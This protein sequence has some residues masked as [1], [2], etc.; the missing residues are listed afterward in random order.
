MEQYNSSVTFCE[1]EKE[2]A[3][4]VAL[5]ESNSIALVTLE[6]ME[7]NHHAVNVCTAQRPAFPFLL[8]TED[9][10]EPKGLIAPNIFVGQRVPVRISE[11]LYGLATLAGRH[12]VS[13]RTETRFEHGNLENLDEQVTAIVLL[14]EDNETNQDVISTQLKMLGYRVELADNGAE[15]LARW[16]GGKFDLVLADCHMPEMDGF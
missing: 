13:A 6:S 14:V 12:A 10:S 1:S 7:K 11:F 8:L 15:G 4:L 2:F 9:R 5:A 3:N 16:G